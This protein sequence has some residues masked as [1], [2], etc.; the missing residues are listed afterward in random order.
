[1]LGD[2]PQM[3]REYTDDGKRSGID[4]SGVLLWGVAGVPTTD[5]RVDAAGVR[6]EEGTSEGK[7]RW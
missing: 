4:I 5:S 7:E 2:G 3:Q 6:E 1:M